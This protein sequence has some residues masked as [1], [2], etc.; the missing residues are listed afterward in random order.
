MD[1]D[2]FIETVEKLD[3]KPGDVLVVR[4]RRYW[5]PRRV[6][7]AL[8]GSKWRGTFIMLGVG[9]SLSVLTD[10]ELADAGLRRI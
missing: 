7:D 5:D 1:D 4:V 10:Q 9:E 3:L 2:Q 8:R 6:A